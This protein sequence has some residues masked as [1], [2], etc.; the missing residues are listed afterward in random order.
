MPLPKLGRLRWLYTNTVHTF[1]KAKIQHS[2]P[3][4]SRVT[5][6]FMQEFSAAWGVA[7]RLALLA[8]SKHCYSTSCR[9]RNLDSSVPMM[10][11]AKDR[12][13]NNVSE[14]L[15]WACAGR[16]LPERNMR[17]H[18]VIIVGIFRKD[19]AKVLRV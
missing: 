6:R 7:V 17:S 11:P 16:V 2:T 9:F 15:D 10:E 8:E 18:L 1:R 14:P 13:R 5:A 12:M 19:S 3:I 4:I